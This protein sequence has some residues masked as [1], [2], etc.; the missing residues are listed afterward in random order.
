M[1]NTVRLFVAVLVLCAFCVVESTAQQGK[2]AKLVHSKEKIAVKTVTQTSPLKVPFITWGGDMA[3]FHANGGLKTKPGTI[4]ADAG[5][6]LELTPGDDFVQQVRDYISGKT[7]FLRGTFRMIGMAGEVIGADPRTQGVVLMQM[8]WSAGDHMVGRSAIKTLNDLK[9]KTVVLQEGGPH[10]GML[11]D[12][13]KD[14]RLTWDDIKVKWAKDLTATD[15]SPLAIF[16][17]D[18]SIDACFVITPD[19][20][21][22]TGGLGMTGSGKGGTVKDARVRSSTADRRRTIADVYVC[23]KDFFDK[24]TA[25]VAKF[26]NAYFIGCEEVM[27]IQDPKKG[28]KV[29]YNALLDLTQSIYTKDVIPSR[30]D[31]DGLLADCNMVVYP[32][33]F[34]FFTWKGTSTGFDG[35]SAKSVALAV[36]LGYAQAEP[37]LPL[38]AAWTGYKKAA[39]IAKLTDTREPKVVEGGEEN[40]EIDAND[41]ELVRFE[42]K[43]DNNQVEFTARRYGEDFQNV[44]NML[45]AYPSAA[46]RIRGHADPTKALRELVYAGMNKGIITRTG[47]AG[48]WKYLLRGR[49]LDLKDTKEMIKLIDGGELAGVK[50]AAGKLIDPKQT[51]RAA[52]NLSEKRVTNVRSAIIQYAKDNKASVAE[53]RLEKLLKGEGVG[54]AEPLIPKPKDRFEAGQNRRVVFQVI[55]TKA[56]GTTFDF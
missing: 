39:I 19:M 50:D 35:F 45:D 30:A 44:L 40:P 20:I 33:N 31:A 52:L 18:P 24:N 37:K 17:K 10:V 29:K 53:K 22:L 11:D 47:K 28:N 16:K 5:L 9:G 6:K 56:E 2:F 14:V 1:R 48:D 4:F 38:V 54:I 49:E 8:T 15:N 42:I 55:K 34:R 25:L 36:K 21:A 41:P 32:G 26:V 3:T 23:R 51:E 27:Q 13:L 43:F 7:P 12:L 46:I